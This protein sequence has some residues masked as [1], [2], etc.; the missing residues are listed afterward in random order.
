MP[1]TRLRGP[2][3]LLALSLLSG[4]GQRSCEETEAD[5]ELVADA[6]ANRLRAGVNTLYYAG[7]EYRRRVVQ[8]EC[9]AYAASPR[10]AYRDEH[11]RG[12]APHLL[13]RVGS[14][15]APERLSLAAPGWDL[16]DLQ[17]VCGRRVLVSVYVP[18]QSSPPPPGEPARLGRLLY[19]CD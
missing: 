17:D 8:V 7:V 1:R 4:C 12:E 18:A 10:E 11:W 14:E 16:D 13:V 3:L 5:L 6:L 19:L 9:F 15:I 2:L